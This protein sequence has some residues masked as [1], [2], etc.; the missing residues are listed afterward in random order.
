MDFD[1]YQGIGNDF[2]IVD[3]Q[4]DHDVSPEQAAQLCDRRFGI[5]ADGVILVLP[6]REAN[7]AA[8]MRVLNADGSIPEMC[9]NGIR[10]MAL[11]V[12]RTRPAVGAQHQV[13]YE[14]DAGPR[15]CAVGLTP[16]ALG[17]DVTV[18]MGPVRILGDLR[19][20]LTGE[21]SEWAEVDLLGVDVGNPHAVSLRRPSAAIIDRIGPRLATHEA[22]PE[23]ANIGFADVKDRSFID[24]VVWERGVG[25]TLACGTGACAA[26]GAAC[27]RGLASWG[28][29]VT[30]KLPG[31]QL[32]I[33]VTAEGGPAR[34][35]GPAR[36]VFSGRVDVG[37]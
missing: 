5:G 37:G 13:V 31:G 27:A 4:S 33:W 21:P 2:I 9:G 17:A 16:D 6:P 28:E 11:H 22:F 8:R 1:K 29:P 14:T 25:L 19:L 30:V 18:G 15:T 10:C 12:A 3:A 26:V 20:G 32:T 35:R 36:H 24:L 23:G 7:H 34:M